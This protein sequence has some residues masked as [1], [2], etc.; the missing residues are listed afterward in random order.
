[1]GTKLP[2]IVDQFLHPTGPN[3]RYDKESRNDLKENPEARN[4]S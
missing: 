2:R 3:S 4:D 1:M